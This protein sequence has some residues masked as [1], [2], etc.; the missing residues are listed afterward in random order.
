MC[1][2]L[3][4]AYAPFPFIVVVIW[5]SCSVIID[6]RH[7]R[8]LLELRTGHAQI[9]GSADIFAWRTVEG[10][11]RAVSRRRRNVAFKALARVIGLD[12]VGFSRAVRG[13]ACGFLLVRR[14]CF[15]RWPPHRSLK[16]PNGEVPWLM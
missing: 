13:G 8:L 10:R 11:G 7:F 1:K 15:L 5:Q 2:P 9:D 12:G 4:S 3:I 16:P 6:G 14:T